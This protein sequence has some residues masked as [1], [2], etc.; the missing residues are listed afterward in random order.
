MVAAFPLGFPALASA[1]S[2][3]RARWTDTQPASG[4]TAPQLR[5]FAAAINESVAPASPWR[6]EALMA[7]AVLTDAQRWLL[8]HH[9]EVR[10]PTAIR[11]ALTK[12]DASS[13]TAS[14][15]LATRFDVRFP[16]QV[17]STVTWTAEDAARELVLVRLMR[18]NLAASAYRS[19]FDDAATRADTALDHWGDH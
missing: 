9:S 14:A 13:S 17:S 4:P 16:N 5:E 15:V 11:D 6:G 12:F 7:L 19:L 18:Q 10:Q 2:V 8:Q 3:A 1:V